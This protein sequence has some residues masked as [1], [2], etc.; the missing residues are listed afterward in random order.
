MTITV[1]VVVSLRAGAASGAASLVR[2]R[3]RPDQDFTLLLFF[4][5]SGELA[6]LPFLVLL[7]VSRGALER[8]WRGMS[9]PDP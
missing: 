1:V 4:F 7:D 9:M 3:E 5:D 8:R 2:A 6:A